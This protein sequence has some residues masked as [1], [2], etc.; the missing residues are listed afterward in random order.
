MAFSVLPPLLLLPLAGAMLSISPLQVVTLGEGV[1][2]DS[3][4]QG[5]LWLGGGGNGG[6]KVP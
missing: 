1:V 5:M 2:C 6:P 3:H 4:M